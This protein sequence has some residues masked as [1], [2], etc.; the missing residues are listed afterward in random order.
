MNSLVV[1][2]YSRLLIQVHPTKTFA[3]QYFSSEYD[4]T[5]AAH[6]LEHIRLKEKV[7][8]FEELEESG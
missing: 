6:I 8:I 1:D 7:Y 3:S 4:K 2:S 5:E